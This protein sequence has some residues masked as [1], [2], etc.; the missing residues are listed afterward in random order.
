VLLSL[1]SVVIILLTRLRKFSAHT[2][3]I[4]IQRGKQMKIA[5][6]FSLGNDHLT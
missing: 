4:R 6:H 2:N 3:T 1:V 5:N